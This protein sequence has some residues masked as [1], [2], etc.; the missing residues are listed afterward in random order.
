MVG[1][2]ETLRKSCRPGWEHAYVNY[3]QLKDIL[4]QIEALGGKSETENENIETEQQKP[5][6]QNIEDENELGV[7]LEDQFLLLLR[8]EVEKVSLFCLSRQGEIAEAVGKLKFEEHPEW[9]L[10]IV[11]RTVPSLQ[12]CQEKEGE[13]EEEEEDTIQVGEDT[14]LLPPGS[15]IKGPLKTPKASNRK[16]SSSSA[17]TG[18][19]PARKSTPNRPLFKARQSLQDS[20]TDSTHKADHFTE[21]GVELLHL[22]RFICVNAMAFRKILKK[23]N[24]TMIQW[25][26]KSNYYKYT[27]TSTAQNHDRKQHHKQ[28]S[29]FF[30]SFM[31]TNYSYSNSSHL[32]TLLGGPEDHLQQLANSESVAAIHSSLKQALQEGPVSL[33]YAP[34][35]RLQC[36]CA[37][38][39]ILREYAARMEETFQGFLSQKAMI[40]TGQNTGGLSH[41]TQQ[42]LQ[43]IIRFQPDSLLLM[44][45]TE[46]YQWHN[47]VFGHRT[48]IVKEMDIQHGGQVI[49]KEQF[50]EED[51]NWGGVNAPSMILNLMSA[52]LY[53]VNYYIVAPTANHY[54]M[55]L[56][57]DGAFGSTLIGASSLAAIFAA[58]LYSFWYSKGRF[59]SALICSALCPLVGN[60]L[61][62]M[63]ISFQSMG[64]ALFGRLLVGFGSAEVVNRQLISA[65]VSFRY[66]TAASALFV[67]ASAIGMSL[68]PLLAAILDMNA[69]RDKAVDIK[70]PYLPAG[71]I[72]FNHVTSP[73]FVMS[74]FYFIQLLGLILVFQEPN[75]VNA[76]VSANTTREATLSNSGELRQMATRYTEY[77][78]A[79]AASPSPKYN[80]KLV[81]HGTGMLGE[82]VMVKELVFENVALPITMLLFGFIELVDE[83][84]ISS[85]SMVCRR[86][87]NWHGSS[88]GILLASLGALV[89]PAHYFVEGASHHYEERAILKV[90]ACA[91]VCQVYILKM[92]IAS[93][94]QS[95]W[96]FCCSTRLSLFLFVC[97]P[98]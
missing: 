29:S 6:Q 28:S 47:R 61:Y 51:S 98:F 42:A 7:L 93:V 73:G 27:T 70:L 49:F 40:A 25:S 57:V 84:L 32:M 89:L 38:I 58:F 30:G 45:N 46:L 35:I 44:N 72:I 10:L 11:P 52:L 4:E 68:G 39:Q 41:A 22:L 53:T 63:A 64:M 67:A 3:E 69:G 71:G 80:Q 65:C 92:Y 2:G 59:K 9:P 34:Q 75:R 21:Q 15:L 18:A 16:A 17:S 88:A 97:L 95:H 66:M 5:Q 48:T 33:H 94:Y 37:S 24:K 62:A 14:A 85:C 76:R 31:S 60:L 50:D 13:E 81:N 78:T 83:V 79:A 82:L 86:Y 1:Y 54:A 56:H 19:M 96:T 8:K 23:H 87:F 36:T 90:R 20:Y 77:G 43:L 12:E 26:D 91:F 74:A 55:L